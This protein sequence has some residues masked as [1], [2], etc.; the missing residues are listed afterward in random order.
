MKKIWI[1]LIIGAI[2]AS[3]SSCQQV[4]AGNTSVLETTVSDTLPTLSEE[5]DPADVTE[6]TKVATPKPTDKPT[7]TPTEVPT[8]VPET[9]ATT[10]ATT[11]A[12]TATPTKATSQPT[13]TTAPAATT[14]A[15]E[16]A[17]TTTKATT[18]RYTE[19]PDAIREGII[20]YCK[21]QGLWF[22]GEEVNGSGQK[23]YELGYYYS[24]QQYIDAFIKGKIRGTCEV[25]S[26]TCWIED[27]WIYIELEESYFPTPAPTAV[28]S[29]ETT[30]TPTPSDTPTPS[31]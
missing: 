14:K 18:P 28:I 29:I 25:V 9:S 13:Q 4:S 30:A 15:T 24:D 23:G 11:V 26:I 2:L 10:A 5:T 6:M 3:V 12:P 1:L 19:N 7:I 17:P 16:L 21:D 20:Q 8:T 31:P 27:G 22:P